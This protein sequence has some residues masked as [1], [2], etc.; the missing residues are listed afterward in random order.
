MLTQQARQGE[1]DM[2]TETA[3]ETG[4][5]LNLAY[6]KREFKGD[7][8]MEFAVRDLMSQGIE[9]LRAHI[10]VFNTYND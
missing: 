10:I 6:Y 9:E 4:R 1:T 2:L 8:F 3:K 7:K 5:L